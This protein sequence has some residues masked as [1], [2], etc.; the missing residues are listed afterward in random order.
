V[1]IRR[2]IVGLT[3]ALAVASLGMVV[4]T[5][6]PRS[7]TVKGAVIVNEANAMD[8]SPIAGVTVSVKDDSATMP[9]TT[10]FSGYF[11]LRLRPAIS[12]GQPITLQ[13]RHPDYQPFDLEVLVG[14][15]LHIARLSSARAAV[16]PAQARAP[17]FLGHVIVRYN[18]ETTMATNIGS[19]AKIFE[20][21]NSGNVPCDRRTRCSPDGK[22]QA[23]VAGVSLDAG[24]GSAF[25]NARLFCI[26]GPCPFTRIDSDNFSRG[27]RV[28]SATVLN[29]SNTTTFSLE[30][31]VV[32]PQVTNLIERSYP[33]ILG[34]RL[35]FSLPASAEGVS[36]ESEVNGEQIIFPLGPMA[37]LSWATCTVRDEKDGAKVFRCE[38]KPGYAFKDRETE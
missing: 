2:T 11:S 19:G 6:R 26:A 10:D 17:T 34:R 13:F 38:L 16:P 25:R 9:A 8:E 30:A 15:R 29:W 18:V 28:I 14:D 20:V 37:S 5:L 22:W 21:V 33:V 23:S 12:A 7:M 3:T 24:E 36:I 1:R 31:E 27:G 35:N 32:R 4:F